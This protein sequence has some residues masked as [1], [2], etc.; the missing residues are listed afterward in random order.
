[1]PK[2]VRR[3]LQI[4]EMT[5]PPERRNIFDDEEEWDNKFLSRSHNLSNACVIHRAW[6][7]VRQTDDKCALARPVACCTA[8]S[9]V[10]VR[11]SNSQIHFDNVGQS[12]SALPTNRPNTV[13][14]SEE[15]PPGE[16]RGG[17]FHL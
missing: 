1:M 3:R 5:L 14:F 17:S 2:P 11:A 12:S 16:N 15:L 8:H 10:G 6:P 4:P 9:A 7:H 13:T